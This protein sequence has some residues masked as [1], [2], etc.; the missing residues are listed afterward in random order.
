MAAMGSSRSRSEVSE[1]PR[2]PAASRLRR[3]IQGP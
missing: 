1:D 3:V 2:L